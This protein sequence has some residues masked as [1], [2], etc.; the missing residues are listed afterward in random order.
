MVHALKEWLPVVREAGRGTTQILFR[1]GGIRDRRFELRGGRS[2]LF[3]TTF[4]V[5]LDGIGEQFLKNPALHADLADVD[6]RTWASIPCELAFEIT[7]A[8]ST[9]DPKVSEALDPWHCYGPRFIEERLGGA[10]MTVVELRAYRLRDPVVLTSA[11]RFF[12]CFAWIDLDA[13][14]DPGRLED[15][16]AC[17]E[18]AV[19]LRRQEMTREALH[20]L[21]DLTELKVPRETRAADPPRYSF[22]IFTS[23]SSPRSTL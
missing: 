19:F 1:R 16:V 14:V 18:D 22:H 8:W 11:D 2:L 20:G 6:V 15:A 3:P 13:S 4:H 5:N 7:G 9:R 23:P 10:S 17:V 12:G 21:D